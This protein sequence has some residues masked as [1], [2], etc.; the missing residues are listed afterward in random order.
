M[1][2]ESSHRASKHGHTKVAHAL[3]EHGVDVNSQDHD[4]WTPLGQASIYGHLE[5]AE[6]LLKMQMS[7]M[8]MT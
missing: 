8:A 7:W 3:L 5:I 6:T 2:V 4:N 1:K